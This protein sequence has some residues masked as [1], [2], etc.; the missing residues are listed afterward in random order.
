MN[1]QHL[2]SPAGYRKRL[3]VIILVT[4]VT[5]LTD[6]AIAVAIG[7]IASA[8]MFAWDHAKHIY[9]TS[10]ENE[11]GSKEYMVHGPIFFGSAANFLE[12]FDAY[13]D[14][15]HIIV[16]FAQ[17]RVTDHSA[18]DAIE[19]LAERYNNVGKTLHLKHLSPTA[20][21]YSIKQVVW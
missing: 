10:K 12:L 11:D 17:S 6:L 2:N 20:V 5:V 8:L 7:V 14:P 4:I 13:N 16:D 9:A 21:N 18:I 1:G 19:T 15:E 3:F